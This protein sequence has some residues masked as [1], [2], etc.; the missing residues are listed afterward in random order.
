MVSAFTSSLSPIGY[1][2]RDGLMAL[3]VV[4]LV[5][6]FV[7]FWHIN[8]EFRG[9]CIVDQQLIIVTLNAFLV[10]SFLSSCAGHQLLTAFKSL[11]LLLMTLYAV[12]PMLATLTNSFSDDTIFALTFMLLAIHLA[13]QD[14]GYVQWRQREVSCIVDI[15]CIA[16]IHAAFQVL[17]TSVF[18]CCHFCFGAAWV[19]IRL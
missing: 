16:S 1:L 6:G 11:F 12:S 5:T 17:C 9:M 7:V 13:I 18:E 3:E 19:A 4:C 10:F 15:L 2:S 8:H 14:Y